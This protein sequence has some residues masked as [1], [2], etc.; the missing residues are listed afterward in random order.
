MSAQQITLPLAQRA[1]LDD[2]ALRQSA[3]ST[4]APEQR[5]RLEALHDK[6][7]RDGLDASEVREEEALLGLYDE[8]LLVRAQAA[9]FLEQRGYDVSD[10]E[11]LTPLERELPT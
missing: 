4:M 9:V 3:R 6:K 7:Q 1:D 11:Q 8:T 5:T 10:P 2:T